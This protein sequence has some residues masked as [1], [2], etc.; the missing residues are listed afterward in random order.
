VKAEAYSCPDPDAQHE[1]EVGFP[2][3]INGKLV[4]LS[5][6]IFCD[7]KSRKDVEVS[8]IVNAR[9]KRYRSD[10]LNEDGT[11]EIVADGWYESSICN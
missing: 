8:M 4:G 2:K 5:A 10:R 11:F 7:L 3:S 6:E 9:G 1:L